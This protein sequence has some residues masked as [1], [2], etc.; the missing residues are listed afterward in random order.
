MSVRAQYVSVQVQYIDIYNHINIHFHIHIHIHIY[1]TL[2]H[3]SVRAQYISVRA[4]PHHSTCARTA[5]FTLLLAYPRM[6]LNTDILS[7]QILVRI[8]YCVTFDPVPSGPL[9]TPCFF[10][11]RPTL[12]K[13]GVVKWW[14]DHYSR[15]EEA[16]SLI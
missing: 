2:H 4:H 3:I 14:G 8:I 5:I 15:E 6:D 12:W 9:R 10:V 16:M 7:I 13:H 1:E 11:Y